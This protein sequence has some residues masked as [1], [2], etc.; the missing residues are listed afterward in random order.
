M[1]TKDFDGRRYDSSG[2]YEIA[3]PQTH[4]TEENT[5]QDVHDSIVEKSKNDL[6][7]AFNKSVLKDLEEEKDPYEVA[8]PR[9]HEW[10]L[11]T[12]KKSNGLMIATYHFWC[13]RC[14][15]VKTIGSGG[16]TYWHTDSHIGDDEDC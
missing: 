1:V 9:K 15:S 2:G 16:P 10:K 5:W 13:S 7:K 12:S 14:G 4:K 3:P 11:I 6:L 8:S